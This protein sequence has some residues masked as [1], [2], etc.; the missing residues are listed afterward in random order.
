MVLVTPLMRELAARHNRP[1]D[2]VGSGRFLSELYAG[3]PF[4]GQVFTIGSRKTP[5]WINPDQWALVRWLR[6]R[7]PGPVYVLQSDAL[8]LRLISRGCTVSAS[9]VATPARFKEHIVE[10]YARLS[11][12]TPGGV[13]LRVSDAELRE[14]DTW[15]DR[16]GLAGRP[17]VLVQ[18]G[19]KRSMRKGVSTD[20]DPKFWPEERWRDVIRGILMESPKALVLII[21]APSESGVTEAIAA[22]SADQR[23]RSVAHDLPL[24]RL[25][26]LF[27][28]ATSLVSV[29]TGP[30]HAAV[31]CGCPVAVLFAAA[32]PRR[33]RPYHPSVPLAVISGP[34]D[35][36]EPDDPAGWVAAHSMAAISVESVLA[37]WRSLRR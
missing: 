29:D 23:V 22:A 26:A 33:I 21:G 2:V 9:A 27:R 11:G 25:F 19:N 37:G 15:L 8:S 32:D 4:V 5:Y 12:S 36:P 28:R 1:C 13:E 35:A 20:Q 6:A 18:P 7:N 16:Q 34:A 30:A 3:L 31:A 14:I 10:H 17:L 24:R